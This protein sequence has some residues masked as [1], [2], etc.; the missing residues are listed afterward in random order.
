MR[1]AAGSAAA[2]G[3]LDGGA[4]HVGSDPSPSLEVLL[5]GRLRIGG[6]EADR[7]E[8]GAVELPEAGAFDQ[9][10]TGPGTIE[11]VVRRALAPSPGGSTAPEIRSDWQRF[12]AL[13]HRAEAL[14][15]TD[16]LSGLSTLARALALVRGQPLEGLRAGWAPQ[17]SEPLRAGVVESAERL[18]RR[19]LAADRPHLAAWAA[20]Q[21]LLAAPG[22]ETLVQLRE[23]AVA[24][25]RRG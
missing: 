11:A 7:S 16:P 4:G 2:A 1:H 14:G 22:A 20:S 25:R 19:A 9:L 24:R 6:V 3:A 23:A 17:V 12:L 5:L 10:G 13:T 21:G 18:A 15:A 8:A